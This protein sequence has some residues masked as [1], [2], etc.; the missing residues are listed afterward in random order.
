MTAS[1]RLL[2]T[3]AL[4][5][6]P[7]LAVSLL[8]RRTTSTMP[9]E[10]MAEGPQSRVAQPTAVLDTA[11]VAGGCFWCME[12]P[13]E[14][15]EGVHAVVSGYTGGAEAAPTYEQVSNQ[16]TGHL[17]AVQIVYDPEQVS[18]REILRVFWM[19][20]DPTDAGGQFADRGPQ[21][22]TAIFYRHEAQRLGAEAS[23]RDL[24]R[25]G[26]FDAPIATPILPASPFYPAEEYHQDYYRKNPTHY[27]RYRR[28]S[29][30]EGY[31]AQ[32]W[33][34]CRLPRDLGFVKPA[35]E[36]MREE[37]TE[38]QFCV[39]QEGA[40]ERPFDNEYWNHKEPGIYV[41]VVSGEPLFASTDK[42]DSGSGWPSFTRPLEG[43]SI[44]EKRDTSMGMVRTEVRSSRADSH[45]G[46]LF[47]DGP[48]PA[49]LR[50]CINSAALR[51]VPVA[52]LEKEGYGEY[53]K[54]F[55]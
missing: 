35:E 47:D 39:T 4:L 48:A 37:L 17:E 7:A 49:G 40:T 14:K 15:L 2:A 10:T 3:A 19:S 44:V 46:H 38:L 50:Y 27:G 32:Q 16:Q 42:Y 1:H 11:L 20:I 52:E 29:G 8:A 30:R 21:Y 54:L 6:I 53:A 36:Q 25:S 5:T 18:F 43:E 13:F 28:G 23:K 41:D 12:P 45:L 34:S 26:A 55:E 33:S 31:L 9:E 22:R 51:F 24:E